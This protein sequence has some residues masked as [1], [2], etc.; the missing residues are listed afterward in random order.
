MCYSSPRY[1]YSI[2]EC[3]FTFAEGVRE[4]NRPYIRKVEPLDKD[5][6]S[7]VLRSMTQV[8]NSD[9]LRANWK[10]KHYSDFW[11]TLTP[12]LFGKYN[13]AVIPGA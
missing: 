7:K 9:K 2:A 5:G 3:P 6:I 12:E 10:N 1:R 13:E 8:G 4:I 11:A